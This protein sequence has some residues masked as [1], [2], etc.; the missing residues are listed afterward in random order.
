MDCS[1]MSAVEPSR[2]TAITHNKLGATGQVR[3]VF[4]SRGWLTALTTPTNHGR[5][6]REGD[7][8]SVVEHVEGAFPEA[9]IA[10]A[11]PVTDNAAV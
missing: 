1:V 6:V 4:H 9:R 5:I 2:G 10:K 11:F 3:T 8:F 7:R